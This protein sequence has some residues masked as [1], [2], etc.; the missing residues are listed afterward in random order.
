ME[1]VTSNDGE[2]AGV[3]QM[4]LA[5]QNVESAELYPIEKGDINFSKIDITEKEIGDIK[6]SIFEKAI[7]SL[8]S[9]SPNTPSTAIPS[10]SSHK[11]GHL[12]HFL[13]L[14]SLVNSLF[15]VMIRL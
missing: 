3:Y 4:K 14:S 12:S 11:M 5:S 7:F 2:R 8:P 13:P 6:S 10:P 1:S 9:C 15:L